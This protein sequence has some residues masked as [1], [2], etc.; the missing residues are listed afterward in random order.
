MMVKVKVIGYQNSR[1][2]VLPVALIQKTDQ[3]D[4]VYVADKEGTARLA[5]VQL[6]QTYEGK[7]E[8]IGGITLGDQVVT[9]GFEELNE[10]DLLTIENN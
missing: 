10:G 1:A 9:N 8:I 5:S 3:G 4:F 6:G 2:F 7:V